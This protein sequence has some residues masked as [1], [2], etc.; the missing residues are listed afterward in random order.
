MGGIAV[1]G[2]VP[3]FTLKDQNGKDQSF[4]KDILPKGAALVVFY[5]GDF[6][7]VCTKQL[8]SYRDNLDEFKNL[9]VQVVG[10]SKN[11]TK[12]HESFSKEYGFNFSLLSDDKREVAKE[13]GTASFLSI[14]GVS[15]AVFI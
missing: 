14:G 3:E 6:T 11:S 8:C 12:D 2:K 7:M 15:R 9:G 5:P 13:F 1:G 4:Y 10:V